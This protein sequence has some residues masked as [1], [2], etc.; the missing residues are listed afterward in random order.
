[1]NDKIG[2]SLKNYIYKEGYTKKSFSKFININYDDLN[3]IIESK[4]VEKDKYYEILIKILNK[5][6][7]NKEKLIDKYYDISVNKEQSQI[8][9]TNKNNLFKLNKEQREI[10]IELLQNE[11]SAKAKLKEKYEQEQQKSW[12][13]SELDNE[14]EKLNKII[15]VLKNIIVLN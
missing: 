14:I 9:K 7:I 4:F 2:T 13:I 12:E 15:M 1:M 8:L 11:I 10:L 5:I 6:N 3:L